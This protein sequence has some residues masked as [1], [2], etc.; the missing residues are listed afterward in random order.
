MDD[1][2]AVA[3][4]HGLQD[5]EEDAP[6]LHLGQHPPILHGYRCTVV[7]ACGSIG[8]CERVKVKG[9]CGRLDRLG[10]ASG[11]VGGQAGMVGSRARRA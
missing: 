11:C 4:V 3:V 8:A 9:G 6:R 7:W 2:V 5:L 1:A 10:D